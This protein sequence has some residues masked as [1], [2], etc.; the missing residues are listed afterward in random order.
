MYTLGVVGGTS[1]ALV[2]LT[3]C[4]LRSGMW[5]KIEAFFLGPPPLQIADLDGLL[6][7]GVEVVVTD[8][9]PW[10]M[11]IC[12]RIQSEGL[13]VVYCRAYRQSVLA[14]SLDISVSEE[15]GLLLDLQDGVV[16]AVADGGFKRVDYSQLTSAQQRKVAWFLD[17]VRDAVGVAK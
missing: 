1:L 4:F 5:W 10:L 17:R 12:W 8:Q 11:G 13:T 14:E 7:S 15:A 6:L 9:N 2:L 3:I 16:V